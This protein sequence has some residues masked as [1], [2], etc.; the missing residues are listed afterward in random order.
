MIYVA[1]Q[2]EGSAFKVYLAKNKKLLKDKGFNWIRNFK[3]ES[4]AIMWINE[5]YLMHEKEYLY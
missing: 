1:T 3:S 2:K 5:S 4:K